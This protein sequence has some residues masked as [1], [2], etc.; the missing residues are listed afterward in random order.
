[1]TDEDWDGEAVPPIARM[2]LLDGDTGETLIDDLSAAYESARAK[3]WGGPVD[4]VVT[5]TPGNIAGV[6]TDA[7]ESRDS[8]GIKIEKREVPHGLGD[9]PFAFSAP[10][11]DAVIK[12][13]ASR[14][15]GT[16]TA[17]QAELTFI[18]FRSSFPLV[19]CG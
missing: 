17:A 8:G 6:E 4:G 19:V 18:C 15:N 1:M 14:L 10:V 13:C 9:F 3:A 16:E 12:N 2:E 5:E 11:C 7:G